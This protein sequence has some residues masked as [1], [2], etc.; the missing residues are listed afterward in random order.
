MSRWIETADGPAALAA[1][2]FAAML[3]VGASSCTTSAPVG[4]TEPTRTS[5]AQQQPAAAPSTEASRGA[6]PT[7]FRQEGEPI[8]RIRL[9]TDI[10]E[11]TLDGPPTLLIGIEGKTGIDKP[12]TNPIKV[13]RL[14]TGWLLRDRSGV[15]T[16]IAGAS[17]GSAGSLSV[18]A[19]SASKP[20]LLNQMPYPGE[21]V[22][23]P[24]AQKNPPPQSSAG[25]AALLGFDVIEHVRLETYLPGVVSRELLPNWSL[26]AFKAQAIAARTYAMH[27]RERSRNNGEPFDLESTQV[28]QVYGGLVDHAVSSRAVQETRGLILTVDGRLLRAY[29]SSTCGGRPASA[30]DVWPTTKGFEFNLDAPIQ[31]SQGPDDA[32]GFSPRS[33]WTV[34]RSREELSKRLSAFGRDQG[35]AVRSLKLLTRVEVR[36]ITRDGRPTG[37]K[38]FDSDGTWYGLSAE[39]MRTACNWVGSSG[40]VQV[41]GQTRVL[42]G[43]LEVVIQGNAVTIKGRGFGHGVGLCQYG[44]EGMSRRGASP[45]QIV[46]HYYPGAKLEKVY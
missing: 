20:I 25:T 41:T 3:A 38:L 27:E 21:F 42:S 33:N 4:R 17:G 39:E 10:K 8:V 30:K 46:Q 16:A 2:S 43:D 22:L 6:S 14:E 31:G 18:K 29:Y 44:A 40:Q 26:N 23:W 32:C 35:F 7:S 13:M 11:L 9:M 1:M 34:Q 5:Q 28:D 37:Y 45:E 15:P 24:R 36:G 12:L 19:E